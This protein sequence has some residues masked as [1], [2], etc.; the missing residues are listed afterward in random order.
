MHI[1]QRGFEE[2]AAGARENERGASTC[3]SHWQNAAV[4]ATGLRGASRNHSLVISPIA[5][6][7]A[8]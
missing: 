7:T 6:G 3:Q 8:D 4:P 1:L 2:A 5:Q